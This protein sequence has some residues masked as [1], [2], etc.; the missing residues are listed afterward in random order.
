[1]G[2]RKQGLRDWVCRSSLGC[3]PCPR[4]L[5]APRRRAVSIS[6]LL[7]VT[8]WA[9]C[10]CALDPPCWFLPPL[11]CVQSLLLEM[12]PKGPLGD[13]NQKCFSY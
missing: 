8:G 7:L 2:A 1:M 9:S 6:L 4:A 11:L 5:H 13:D 10:V 12:C 3:V